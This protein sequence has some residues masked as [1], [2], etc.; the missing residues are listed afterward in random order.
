MVQLNF[1]MEYLIH[2]KRILS[3]IFE[4][5]DWK[6][7]DNAHHIF[8]LNTMVDTALCDALNENKPLREKSIVINAVF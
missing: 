4:S 1:S 2:L 8:Y 7:I 3:D 5:V 6:L